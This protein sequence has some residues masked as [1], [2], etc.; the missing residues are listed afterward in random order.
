MQ[1]RPREQWVVNGQEE[2]RPAGKCPRTPNGEAEEDKAGRI[3]QEG[4]VI[5]ACRRV[6]EDDV[7]HLCGMLLA[8]QVSSA[9]RRNGVGAKAID[10]EQQTDAQNSG[11]S[12]PLPSITHEFRRSVLCLLGSPFS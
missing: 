10:G 1:E 8:T 5:D 7:G 4:H 12:H 3:E 6:A 2:T 11:P 9:E